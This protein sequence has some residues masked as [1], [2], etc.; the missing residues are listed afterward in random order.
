MRAPAVVGSWPEPFAQASAGSDAQPV[1]IVCLDERSVC[2][3][4]QDTLD[5][6]GAQTTAANVN[7]AGAGPRLLVGTW[8]RVRRDR[9]AAQI[10][11]GP[12]T[13]GVFARF[14]RSGSG[15]ALVALD[16]TASPTAHVDENGGLVAAVRHGDDPPTWVVTGTDAGAVREAVEL[17]SESS[18]RD[19][20]AVAF[21]GANRVAVPTQ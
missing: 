8:D 21:D 17:L 15:W 11:A 7:E 2:D 6:V 19:H 4:A 1:G 10:E 14:E 13:S 3:R 5:D 18:L 9:A 16:H 12:A 20:Y